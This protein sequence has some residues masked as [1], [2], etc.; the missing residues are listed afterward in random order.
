MTI[1]ERLAAVREKMQPIQTAITDLRVE[2]QQ[3]ELIIETIQSECE[4]ENV[5]KVYKGD[6]H[7]GWSRCEYNIFIS[8][9]C[10]LCNKVWSAQE[11]GRY[12]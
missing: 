1:P 4:H 12:Y 10:P 8:Y 5:N 3:Y 6:D 7:D 2:L 9:H 11:K